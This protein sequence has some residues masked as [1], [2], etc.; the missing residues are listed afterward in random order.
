M[1]GALRTAGMAGVEGPCSMPALSPCFS[2]S[3]L[4]AAMTSPAPFAR[5]PVPAQIEMQGVSGSRRESVSR[6]YCSRASGERSRVIAGHYRKQALS[7]HRF[8]VLSFNRFI[9]PSFYRFIV[10]SFYRFIVDFLQ[11]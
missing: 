6:L 5:Q 4:K 9:V 3:A 11:R 10:P 1:Q 8:I 2:S 7:F